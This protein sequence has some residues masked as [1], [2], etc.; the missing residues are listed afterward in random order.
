VLGK[1]EVRG[2]KNSNMTSMMTK[3]WFLLMNV[4][5]KQKKKKCLDKK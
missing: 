1:K 2:A 3:K 5:K 4:K